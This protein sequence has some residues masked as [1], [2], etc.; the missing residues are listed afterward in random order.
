MFAIAQD[1]TRGGPCRPGRFPACRR[2]GQRTWRLGVG[3]GFRC[4]QPARHGRCRRVEIAALAAAGVV[5]SLL[6]DAPWTAS[7]V[8]YAGIVFVLS[9][10]HEGVRLGR[11]T[12]LVDL[13]SEQTRAHYTAVSNTVIG[14]LLLLMGAVSGTAFSFGAVYALGFLGACSVIAALMAVRLKPVS[15]V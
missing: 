5:A 6:L 4:V 3:Q 15:G 7:P 14:A 11:S 2:A 9:L 10:A 12:Y 1:Q 13:A 8:F